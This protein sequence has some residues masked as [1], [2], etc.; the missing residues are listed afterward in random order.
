MVCMEEIPKITD[1]RSGKT[2]NSAGIKNTHMVPLGEILAD[3]LGGEF[4]QMK[5]KNRKSI[6]GLQNYNFTYKKLIKNCTL[7]GIISGV[8][9]LVIFHVIRS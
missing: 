1:P 7:L 8:V 9:I 2:E 3:H 6:L 5:V 4:S